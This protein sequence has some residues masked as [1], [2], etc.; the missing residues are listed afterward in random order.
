MN[1]KSGYNHIAF[2]RPSLKTPFRLKRATSSSLSSS[3]LSST[4]S[5]IFDESLPRAGTPLTPPI[6]DTPES[7]NVDRPG[8]SSPGKLSPSEFL[9]RCGDTSNIPSATPATTSTAK[10]QSQSWS[11]SDAELLIEGVERLD[12]Q[13]D[14]QASDTRTSLGQDESPAPAGKLQVRKRGLQSV[15]RDNDY[16][17]SPMKNGALNPEN[18]HRHPSRMDK[19]SPVE[20]KA[21]CSLNLTEAKTTPR[22]SKG[23]SVETP[24]LIFTQIDSEGKEVDVDSSDAIAPNLPHP[25]Q[26]RQESTLPAPRASHK[27]SVSAPAPHN[28]S[29]IITQDTSIASTRSSNASP[30]QTNEVEVTPFLAPARRNPRRRSTGSVVP[31]L[32]VIPPIECPS[33]RDNQEVPEAFPNEPINFLEGSRQ[34]PS[35][36]PSERTPDLYPDE[37]PKSP[38][39]EQMH[40]EKK[41]KNDLKNEI[42]RVIRRQN[43]KAA[44]ASTS[45]HGYVYIFKS[46]RF[47]GDVKIGSTVKAP[48]DRITK[49]GKLCN[50][51]PFHVTDK[52]DKAFRFCRIVE[53]IVHAELYNERKIFICDRCNKKHRFPMVT[54]KKEPGEKE[55][56]GKELGVRPTEHGEWF[57][58]SETKALEVVNKWRDWMIREEPYTEAAALRS[59]WVWKHDMGT[60]GMKGT[61]EEWEGELEVWRQFGWLDEFRFC[62][63][64]LD[65]WLREVS[66]LLQK[67]VK[68]EGSV[69]VLAAGSYLGIVGVNL[70]SCLKVAIV[71]SL[72]RFISKL[73]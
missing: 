71:L 40:P 41:E 57:T 70:T 10:R 60:K 39:S 24:S 62:L 30:T 7:S 69:L 38:K 44:A 67:L 54:G 68:I 12:I 50:F 29:N 48:L 61:E 45:N 33:P 23:K 72:Y 15:Q 46:D 42:L 35:S 34:S 11:D 8:L 25:I 56:G 9:G 73:R 3:T 2:D 53:Q 59:R 21:Q 18:E 51:I 32:T 19:T 27:R 13:D 4:T 58:I 66:P 16:S 1:Q 43:A 5:S 52:N 28:K 22:V 17:Q 36:E 20:P 37:T 47:P 49:W 26:S 31:E 14:E 55:L 64:D 6:P 65:K 63:Y